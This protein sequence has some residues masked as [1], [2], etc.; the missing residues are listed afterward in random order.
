MHSAK[1][2]VKVPA[3]RLPDDW[4]PDPEPTWVT[5]PVPV[6]DVPGSL[7]G[8][9]ACDALVPDDPSAV[10]VVDEALGEPPPQAAQPGGRWPRD[11][12]PGV[13][14]CDHD[15]GVSVSGR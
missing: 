2:R 6:F 13:L 7:V 8:V 5:T 15:G 14:L 3:E 12:P 9:V 11:P 1:A 4:L 10:V